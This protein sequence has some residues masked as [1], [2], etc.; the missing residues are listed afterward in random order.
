MFGHE[1]GAF[2]DAKER[3]LGRLELAP[4]GTLYLDEI[5][6]MPVELQTKVLRVLQERTLERV[7]GTDAIRVDAPV[8]AAPNRALDAPLKEGRFRQALHDRLNVE[9]FHV[10]T[11]PE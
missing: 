2:T 9:T 6:D 3:R 8:L 1:R 11:L 7:G 4:G 10:P 5:G